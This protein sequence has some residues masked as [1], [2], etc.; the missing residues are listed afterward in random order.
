M[1]FSC[2]FPE[3]D[4]LRGRHSM[5]PSMSVAEQREADQRVAALLAL[6]SRTR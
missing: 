3:L 6:E 2:C 5:M 1:N 4:L